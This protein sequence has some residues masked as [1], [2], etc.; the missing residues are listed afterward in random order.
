[1]PYI[2]GQAN[3]KRFLPENLPNK[4]D[5][6]R[7]RDKP[8]QCHICQKPFKLFK[9]LVERHASKGR[10]NVFLHPVWK[11]TF[12]PMDATSA[13]YARRTLKS[14]NCSLLIGARERWPKATSPNKSQLGRA[15]KRR[16]PNRK[17]RRKTAKTTNRHCW[18][19]NCKLAST[20][21]THAQMRF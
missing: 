15:R 17:P 5:F 16:R 18:G 6:Q 1:M 12:T 20:R 14:P 7:D 13:M 21:Q 2:V 19:R 3:Y 11:T 4:A 8:Y 9:R 10:S